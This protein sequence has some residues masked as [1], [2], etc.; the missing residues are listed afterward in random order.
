MTVNLFLKRILNNRIAAFSLLFIVIAIPLILFL[1]A[2]LI[3]ETGL[4]NILVKESQEFTIDINH[5]NSPIQDSTLSLE[6]R[7]IHENNIELAK[8]MIEQNQEII[9]LLDDQNY[10]EAYDLMLAKKIDAQNAVSEHPEFYG[11]HYHQILESIKSEQEFYR[12]LIDHRLK[13]DEYQPV[14]GWTFAFSIWNDVLPWLISI[15]LI[16]ILSAQYSKKFY[17]QLNIY[18]LRPI[19]FYH[20]ALKE[21]GLGLLLALLLWCSAL[22]LAFGLGSLFFE[23][24]SLNY[25]ILT[26]NKSN[27]FA[28]LSLISIIGPTC[29][30]QIFSL[31][32]LVTTIYLVTFIFKNKLLS[33][34]MTL[35]IITGSM[36]A[37]YFI[38]FFE[39]A[40]SWL[41]YTYLQS[42]SVITGQYNITLPRAET[43]LNLGIGVN[44]TCILF[45]LMLTFLIN[46]YRSYKY[47]NG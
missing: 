38:P 11:D 36:I 1:N 19:S 8:Q 30:L 39:S 6:D 27:G 5:T 42:A 41:P 22:I 47:R 40:A 23:P 33:M 2:Q 29:L 3:N 18:R 13:A 26:F 7:K 15:L 4:R 31:L 28:W 10:Y 20:E 32:S 37:S 34:V 46:N 35:L 12:Y 14:Y 17:D 21:I 44:S 24:G 43:N 9:Q 45:L 16:V 25:P